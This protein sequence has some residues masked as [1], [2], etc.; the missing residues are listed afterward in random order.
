MCREP[1]EKWSCTGLGTQPR[2]ARAFCE[3]E[4]Y[5]PYVLLAIRSAKFPVLSRLQVLTECVVS[6]ISSVLTPE[7]PALE[8]TPVKTGLSALVKTTVAMRDVLSQGVRWVW[9]KSST[10]QRGPCC[11][12]K[13]TK[14]FNTSHKY[15][16]LRTCNISW[17]RKNPAYQTSSRIVSLI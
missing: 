6:R 15:T 2:T 1:R 10:V 8:L 3:V 14:N 13:Q 4:Q 9:A 7:E 12:S 16:V 11:Y 5:P 17:K